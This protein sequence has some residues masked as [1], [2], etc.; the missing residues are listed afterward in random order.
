MGRN[1]EWL[2]IYRSVEIRGNSDSLILRLKF[3]IEARRGFTQSRSVK[4]YVR[5]SFIDISRGS[6]LKPERRT[7]KLE[8]FCSHAFS[9][10]YVFSVVS[11]FTMSITDSSHTFEH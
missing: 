7:K 10:F 9:C 4:K 1:L 5:K 3:H 6:A 2:V 11:A 8:P